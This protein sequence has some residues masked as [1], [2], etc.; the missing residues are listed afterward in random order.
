M[1]PA[2]ASQP[3]EGYIKKTPDYTFEG[4]KATI[5]AEGLYYRNVNEAVRQAFA[6]GAK[7]VVLNNVNGQRY[8]GT[9]ISGKGLRIEVNGVP[10]NDMAAFM[11]GPTIRVFGFPFEPRRSESWVFALAVVGSA[12]I[13]FEYMRRRFVRE[14]DAIA[15]E[16]DNGQRGNTEANA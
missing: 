16:I 13:A 3:M 10:G 1:N 6:A 12:A 7:T 8:I 15:G 5:D 2:T 9:G 4:D 11:D 14:W